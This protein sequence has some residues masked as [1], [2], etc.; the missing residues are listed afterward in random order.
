MNTRRL[1]RTDLVIY[2]L[3][4]AIVSWG[5]LN[6][7]KKHQR[8]A[9]HEAAQDAANKAQAIADTEQAK[10]ALARLRSVWNADD[11][12]EHRVYTPTN[13]A[14]PYSLDIEH[15]LVNGRPIIIVGEVQDVR[16]SQNQNVPLVLIQ[17]HPSENSLDLRFSLLTTREVADSILSATGHS[18]AAEYETF[19]AVATIQHVEKIEQ[20]PDK[21]GNDG[22]YFLAHGTL[23]AAYATHLIMLNPKELGEN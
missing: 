3:L 16:S 11:S 7:L 17:S 18:P 2:F 4:I 21:D 19:I 20:S 14:A 1:V 10:S 13:E 15:A 23:H 22:D 8:E 5:G 9:K 12:W 6:R